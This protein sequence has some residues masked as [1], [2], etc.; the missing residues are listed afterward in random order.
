M[1]IKEHVKLSE[2]TTIKMGGIA[3]KMYIPQNEDELIDVINHLSPKYFIGGGSNL[4]IN[5]TILDVVVNLREFNKN[6]ESLGNG[7]YILGASLRL[8]NVIK[9]IN[10]DG[11]GGIEY[12]YSVPGLIGGAVV[13]NAGRGK[14]FNKC[15]S[16]YIISIKVFHNGKIEWIPKDECDFS[17]RYSIF[18]QSDYLVLAARM[19][20]E[21]KEKQETERLRLER[22][23]HCKQFQDNSK[24]NFGSVFS[25]SN[26]FIM[27][28]FQFKIIGKKDGIMFSSKTPNWILNCGGSFDDALLLINRV[29]RIHKLFGKKC[30]REV[31][32]WNDTNIT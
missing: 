4:L 32:I 27:K 21:K 10:E 9:S 2:I 18:K 12:L 7:E 19:K 8:Q 15:I 23:E 30:K 25:E 31:I 24:P 20:F 6:I 3:E 26:S 14:R 17:H 29:E 16:D 28:L 5:D 1:I 22:I 11:Y 13:M